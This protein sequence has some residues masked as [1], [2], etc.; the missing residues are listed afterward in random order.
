MWNL[1]ETDD[2]DLSK[3]TKFNIRLIGMDETTIQINVQ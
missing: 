1:K 3:R 2:K